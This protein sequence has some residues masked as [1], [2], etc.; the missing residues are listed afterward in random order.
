MEIMENKLNTQKNSS[1]KKRV[2]LLWDNKRNI[3]MRYSPFS[4]QW[5]P[6]QVPLWD[7]DSPEYKPENLDEYNQVMSQKEKASQSQTKPTYLKG[8]L[9]NIANYNHSDYANGGNLNTPIPF[10]PQNSVK[11]HSYN[12]SLGNVVNYGNSD[13]FSD[14]SW[15]HMADNNR[16][17]TSNIY[18]QRVLGS[19]KDKSLNIKYNPEIKNEGQIK[20]TNEITFK[21]SMPSTM[22]QTEE[23]IHAGQ[24]QYY[25]WLGIRQT[26]PNINKEME[27]KFIADIIHESNSRAF[28]KDNSK[29][30]LSGYPFLQ[31]G[32]AREGYEIPENLFKAYMKTIEGIVDSGEITQEGIKIYSEVGSILDPAKSNDERM[33]DDKIPPHYLINVILDGNIKDYNK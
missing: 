9:T 14:S 21:N 29:D 24:Q 28:D 26:I 20:G 2:D 12:T 15:A 23:F 17:I 10:K 31:I 22:A 6:Y 18:G 30:V 27:A 19:I 11:L 8:Y 1:F 33:F 3:Y 4:D 13:Y 16:R 7:I 5:L 25:D 32:M